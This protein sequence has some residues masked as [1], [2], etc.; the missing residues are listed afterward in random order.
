MDGFRQRHQPVLIQHQLLQ[1][2]APKRHKTKHSESVPT[3]LRRH[4]VCVYAAP[5]EA[6]WD[7]LQVVVGSHEL[8]QAAEFAHARR[9]PV[10][11]QFVRIHV[12]L[13]QLG[14]L[15]DRRLTGDT[16]ASVSPPFGLGSGV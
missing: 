14:Q 2:V 4:R 9:K 5:A 10:E 7:E 16:K 6:L 3:F 15:A 8:R 13:L 11:V 12:Q 1:F